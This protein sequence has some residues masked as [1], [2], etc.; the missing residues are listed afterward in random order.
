M[1]SNMCTVTFT[2]NGNMG[3][4]PSRIWGYIDCPTEGDPS[5]ASAASCDAH[6]EFLFEN[7]GQ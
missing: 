3:V 5:Q 4:A 2:Q 6:A 7:C 1:K